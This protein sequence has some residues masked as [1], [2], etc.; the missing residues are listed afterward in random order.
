LSLCLKAPSHV[1]D[2]FISWRALC[3]ITCRPFPIW[4]KKTFGALSWRRPALMGL[5]WFEGLQPWAT[6]LEV[7]TLKFGEALGSLS[8]IWGP[9]PWGYYP[10]VYHPQICGGPQE[11]ASPVL[12][13]HIL[14]LPPLRLQPSNLRKPLG[15]GLSCF[16]GLHP[17]APTLDSYNPQIWGSPWE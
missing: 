1:Q 17:E 13:A 14:R 4:I 6:T 5:S 3:L 9:T 15:A 10:W 12:R 11:Q 7:T 2:S 16:E 8:L